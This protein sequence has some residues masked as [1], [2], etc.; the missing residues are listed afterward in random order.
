MDQLSATRAAPGTVND[1]SYVVGP[2]FAVVL[3]GCTDPGRDSGCE[4]DV[5]WLVAR[6]S[7]HL[8]TGLVSGESV[9]L[10]ET[11][12]GAIAATMADHAYCD[13]SNPDSPSSTVTVLR[14]TRDRIEFLI[15]GDSPLLIEHT[16]GRVTHH[17][18]DQVDHLPGYSFD[19]V[20]HWRNRTGGF[21]VASTAPEAAFHGVSG[22]FDRVGVRRALLMTDGVSRLVERYGWTWE[23]LFTAAVASGPASLITAVHEQDGLV[24]D[25]NGPWPDP[26]P[27]KRFDDA[28][29]VLCQIA[30][31]TDR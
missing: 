6:L 1:D 3:D 2:H 21:W 7:A 24:G 17:V 10:T 15:L 23:R 26:M 11:V 28:T 13:L 16:D 8:A 25:P 14:E 30:D 5:P 27:G 18:D 31:T 20:A 19:E 4:H 22:S 12:S 9:A 29:T